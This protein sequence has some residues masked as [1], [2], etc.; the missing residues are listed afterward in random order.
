MSKDK[1]IPNSFWAEVVNTAVYILNRSPTKAILNRT[2]YEAWHHRKPQVQQF[3]IFGCIAYAHIDDQQREKFDHKGEKYI[4]TRYS[5]E[6]K[7]YRLYN[8][9]TSKF[10]IAQDVIFDEVETWKWQE[11]NSR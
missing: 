11:D 5:D 2:P 8:P 7:G 3:R 10:I 6:S 1:G 4:F 9:D